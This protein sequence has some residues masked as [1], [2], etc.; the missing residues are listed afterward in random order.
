MAVE[1][2]GLEFANWR[3]LDHSAPPL[4]GEVL[5]PF[6]VEELECQAV[7]N[8]A[9][10]L[11]HIWR[12]ERALVLGLR[13]RRLPY[14]RPTMNEWRARGWSTA[15]RNSGGAA[16]P[17][18]DGVVNVSLILPAAT[19][20]NLQQDFA[21]M[22]ALIS[23]TVQR[24]AV[25][26]LVRAGEITGA[27]CPGEFD[28]AID[29]YKFCGIAQRRKLGAYVIQAFVVVEGSGSERANAAASYYRQAAGEEPSSH[30]L[31]VTQ[32]STR[33]LQELLGEA[34]AATGIPITAE[35]YVQAVKEA[36]FDGDAQVDESYDY[37][38]YDEG[39]LEAVIE[40]MQRRY[41]S[42]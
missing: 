28:L 4:R 29:G 40:A 33:S 31:V 17:L 12:H 18:D 35:R 41:D 34:A 32:N 21:R 37:S 6:A 24:L 10:P 15:V 7:A 39:Q 2:E 30:A 1:I 22:A 38:Y 27:Y 36:M 20:V 5:T 8:G 16:V 3:L 25:D 9:P 13:D 19:S 11:L 23:R 26:A 42:N 14:A